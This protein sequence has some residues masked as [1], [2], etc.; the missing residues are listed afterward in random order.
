[1][2]IYRGMS[3]Y[4]R[5]REVRKRVNALANYRYEL[6]FTIPVPV[7]QIAILNSNVQTEL[8]RYLR[9]LFE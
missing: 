8:P 4:G 5:Y 2:G 6:S 7:I 3:V 9:A 1:M